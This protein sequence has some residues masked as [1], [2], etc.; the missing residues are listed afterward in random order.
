MA[1][2]MLKKR[3]TPYLIAMP[4]RRLLVLVVDRDDDVGVK[5]GTPGPV[6]GEEQNLEVAQKLALADPEDSDANTIFA[7][8]KIYRELKEKGENVEIATV[9]GHKALGFVADT[10][11]NKQLEIVFNQFPADGIVF[12]TDGAEDDQVIPILLSY[13]PIISKKTVVVKQAVQLERTFYVIKNALRDKDL[14]P[15]ILGIPGI[16]LLVWA[17]F[18]A[19]GIRLFLTIT[20]AYL[21]LKAFGIWD[22]AEGLVKT[23]LRGISLRGK[24]ALFYIIAL[25]F[26]PIGTYMAYQNYTALTGTEAM[27]E[28]F[29]TMVATISISGIAYL[30]G[31]GVD[32]HFEKRAYA[33]GR[34]IRYGATLLIVWA[35]TEATVNLILQKAS[36]TD[37]YWVMGAA[38]LFYIVVVQFADLF[39]ESVRT[40]RKLVGARAYD[41]RGN[42]VGV[43]ADVDPEKE[44]IVIRSG[45]KRIK[46]P[47]TNIYVDTKGVIVPL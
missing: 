43:V 15:I 7:A 44:I 2:S 36:V 47:A 26:L 3:G 12:V 38:S 20:G 42:V 25:A 37:L 35:L 30:V 40:S 13:A 24:G 9:T 27:L 19:L 31:R 23:I 34:Y 11:I 41:R 1:S 33:I 32:A 29:R 45:N 21:V 6:I 28:A 17:L 46:V 16:A 18:G 5:I 39:D 4:G 10:N 14:A 8:L 22:A